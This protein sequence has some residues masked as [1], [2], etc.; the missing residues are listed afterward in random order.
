M[1]TS[2]VFYWMRHYNIFCSL[3]WQLRKEQTVGYV[4]NAHLQTAA[5]TQGL[6]G[7]SKDRCL[8]ILRTSLIWLLVIIIFFMNMKKWIVSQWFENNE[9]LKENVNIWL[10]SKVVEFYDEGIKKLVHKYDKC[11]NLS[12]NFM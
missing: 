12:G 6:L 3:F 7:I 1:C 8:T 4:E 11:L 10:N 2:E 9:K 5:P